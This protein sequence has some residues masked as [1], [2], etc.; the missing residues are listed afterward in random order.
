M[1]TWRPAAVLTRDSNTDVFLW[2]LQNFQELLFYH[3]WWLLLKACAFVYHIT[4]FLKKTATHSAAKLNYKLKANID[5][6]I[7]YL[8][9]TDFRLIS[10]MF[11]CLLNLLLQSLCEF[12]KGFKNHIR[13][14]TLLKVLLTPG[15]CFYLVSFVAWLNKI[16]FFSQISYWKKLHYSWTFFIK[17]L[18]NF[19]NSNRSW[20][21]SDFTMP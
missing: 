4:E 18:L 17:K 2:I 13:Y 20:N 6:T 1:Q 10:V 3:P 15:L 14:L 21:E 9:I 16:F 11:V 19:C 12:I 5:F 7:L 8:L